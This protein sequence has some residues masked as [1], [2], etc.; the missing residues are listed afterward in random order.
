MPQ[1]F[2]F[3]LVNGFTIIRDDEGV[4]ADDQHL[5]V[6]YAEE[7]IYEMRLNGELRRIEGDWRLHIR[8]QSGA[9][10]ATLPV[11]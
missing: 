2:Y 8:T 10:L 4:E 11:S 3:D 5:A 9:V 6:M 1:R 7:A